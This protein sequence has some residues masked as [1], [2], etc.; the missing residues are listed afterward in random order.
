MISKSKQSLEP[1]KHIIAKPFLNV[2]P[3]IL[4]VLGLIFPLLFFYFVV[5][6]HLI[7]ALLMVAGTVFDTIDGTVARAKHNSTTFGFFLDSTLDRIA[8]FFMISAFG[9]AGLVSWELVIPTLGLSFLISFIRT[10]AALSAKDESRLA[11]GIIE[12]PERIGLL[13]LAISGKLFLPDFNVVSINALQLVFML[14]LL[15]SAVTVVQRFLRS[16]EVLKDH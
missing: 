4:T 15:L 7:L 9:F 1:F 10:R 14:L 13:A 6:D 5:S 2:P 12:R 8:D 16:Y 3:N 11:V